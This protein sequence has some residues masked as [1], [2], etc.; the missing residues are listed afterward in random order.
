MLASKKHRQK[1]KAYRKIA[2]SLRVILGA[3]SI[4]SFI[5]TIENIKVC[6]PLRVFERNSYDGSPITRDRE[7]VCA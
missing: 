7:E 2:K 6:T 5:D 1:T 4:I 3:L